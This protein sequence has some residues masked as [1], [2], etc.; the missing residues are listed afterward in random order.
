MKIHISEYSILIVS[1]HGLK[2]LNCPF[3]VKVIQENAFLK[4]NSI[5]Q[6]HRVK[7]NKW[8]LDYVIDKLPIK[9]SVFEIL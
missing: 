1:V 8:K 9:H 6:V 4:L 5:Q 7:S 3:T 2:R